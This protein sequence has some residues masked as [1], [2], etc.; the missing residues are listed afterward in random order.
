MLR[1]DAP[2]LDTSSVLP[3]V[4]SIAGVPTRTDVAFTNKSGVEKRAIRKEAEKHLKKLAPVLL[5]LLQKDEVVLY[6]AGGCA[7]M[8]GVEQYTF[9]IFAQFVSRVTMVFTNMRVFAFRVEHNGNWRESLKVCA[10]SEIAS[11]KASGVILTRYLK[12]TYANGKKESYW[13]LKQR[14]KVKLKTL[15]AK[16]VEPPTGAARYGQGMRPVCP[17]CFSDLA[18]GHYECSPCGQRFREEHSL[19][20]RSFIPGAVY[21]FAKQTG[22][23]ILHAIF[24]SLVTL[25]VVILTIGTFTMTRAEKGQDY[26]V[27]AGFIVLL[28]L[29]E[30]SVAL[31]HARRFVREFIPI[32]GTS[33]AGQT[34]SMTAGK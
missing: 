21:F 34:M 3:V 15:M 25:E 29:F 33:R 20:W 9:G 6:V 12:L 5:R 10:L 1:A 19:W 8:T 27:G 17:T 31:W 28:W 30:R 32:P 18:E 2:V 4:Q 23:G 22:M 26:W 14:D 13:A 11:A 7:P 24:D 16:L